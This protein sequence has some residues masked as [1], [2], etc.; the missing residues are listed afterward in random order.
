M[1]FGSIL[2]NLASASAA[3]TK[4][5]GGFLP[6]GKGKKHIKQKVLLFVKFFFAET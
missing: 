2:S 3:F 1:H 5:C 4:V 6:T